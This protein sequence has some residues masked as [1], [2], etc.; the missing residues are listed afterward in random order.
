MRKQHPLAHAVV[1]AAAWSDGGAEFVYGD[2]T[3]LSFMDDMNTF[4]AVRSSDTSRTK[5]HRSG[6]ASHRGFAAAS[7]N[8][9]V[10]GGDDAQEGEADRELCFTAWTLSTYECKVRA[11]LSVY[12]TLAERPRL[13]STLLPMNESNYR[14]PKDCRQVVLPDGNR[15]GLWSDPGPPMHTLLLEKRRDLFTRYVVYGAV[16]EWLLEPVTQQPIDNTVTLS[17]S[18]QETTTFSMHEVRSSTGADAHPVSSSSSSK[19]ESSSAPQH[20]Q[21]LPTQVPVGTV[22]ELWCAL[23]RVRL[24]V[25]VHRETFTVRWPAPVIRPDGSRLP[26]SSIPLY[27][28]PSYGETACATS[29]AVHPSPSSSVLFTY[30]EQTF[31]ACNPPQVWEVM[32]QM[33]LE[34]DAELPMTNAVYEVEGTRRAMPV[35]ETTWGRMGESTAA[36]AQADAAGAAQWKAQACSVAEPSSADAVFVSEDEGGGGWLGELPAPHHWGGV[37]NHNRTTHPCRFSSLSLAQATH[38]A[39]PR[40]ARALDAMRALHNSNDGIA[41]GKGGAQLSWMYEANRCA[42]SGCGG[43]AGG[44]A[45]SV[46]WCLPAPTFKGAA[47]TAAVEDAAHPAGADVIAWVAEDGSVVHVR[48]DG[49]G[50]TVLHQRVSAALSKPAVYRLSADGAAVAQHRLP[51]TTAPLRC[52]VRL[53]SERKPNA[54]SDSRKSRPGG[55]CNTL[56]PLL[57]QEANERNVSAPSDREQFPAGLPA[58]TTAAETTIDVAVAL[59]DPLSL[60]CTQ[61]I[62]EDAVVLPASA[63]S[64]STTLSLLTDLTPLGAA[65]LPSAFILP[66]SYAASARAPVT[67][68]TGLQRPSRACAEEALRLRCNRYLSSIADVCVQ[69]SQ[70]NCAVA[71][72]RLK[73][74]VN[75]AQPRAPHAALA[76]YCN[77]ALFR[78]QTINTISS[79]CP[80][81]TRQPSSNEAYDAARVSSDCI[82]HLTSHLDGIGTFTAL[83]NGTVRGHFDDRTIFTLIPGSNELDESQLLATCVLRDA[84]RCTMH[85]AQCRPGHP[86]F[87]YLAYMLPFRRF[88]YLQAAQRADGDD[89]ERQRHRYHDD[90]NIL[91]LLR[92]G[93]MSPVE[94]SFVETCINCLPSAQTSTDVG[95][96]FCETGRYTEKLL[97]RRDSEKTEGGGEADDRSIPCGTPPV[98]G[99]WGAASPARGTA[100]SARWG[101]TDGPRTLKLLR[102]REVAEAYERETRLREVL[103]ENEKL[104]QATRALL[105]D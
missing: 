75:R 76:A 71:R 33:A 90:T 11:A 95:S 9:G 89:E 102:D 45:P 39:A 42:E 78:E 92:E 99:A 104:S 84:K 65:M 23:R 3:I 2:G 14:L 80:L 28:S 1:R 64:A 94:A 40:T 100:P 8:R 86:I 6:N 18:T 29:A 61:Y 49:Q 44:S 101:I 105:R 79:S 10:V 31:P 62:D 20:P 21:R 12:N 51:P 4:A 55:W 56:S 48:L 96:P 88:V 74:Q 57:C 103:A 35:H 16:H 98:D 91:H 7:G 68:V 60:H 87:R 50:Y 26:P 19:F 30:V 73:S 32:L 5:E 34:M 46:Y 67:P 81:K 41:S 66:S 97:Q 93:V 52:R 27:P 13:I 85:V 59:V 15:C 63:M 70:V 82:V 54:E 53:S 69:L 24:T 47:A 83:T 72:E 77:P 17:E 43:G 22:L 25:A 37:L 36:A 38:L 58:T